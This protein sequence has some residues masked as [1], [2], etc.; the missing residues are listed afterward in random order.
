MK[1]FTIF[2]ITLLCT[3]SLVTAA[4]IDIIPVYNPPVE[5]KIAPLDLPPTYHTTLANG[6]R[7]TTIPQHEVP[8]VSFT[9]AIGNGALLDPIGKEGTASMTASLLDRGTDKH[10]GDEIA[11]ELDFMATAISG[12]SDWYNSYVRFGCLTRYLEPTLALFSEVL[13][14]PVFPQREFDSAIT[15]GVSSMQQALDSPG[16]LVRKHFRSAVYKGSRY[17]IGAEGDLET[18]PAITREDVVAFHHEYYSPAVTELIIVGDVE[19]QE[20]V[21][22]VEAYLGDWRG[23]ATES[24]VATAL[25][26]SGEPGVIIINKPEATNANLRFGHLGVQRNHPDYY[27]LQVMNS[28]LGG[29]GFS[30]R[31][32]QRIRTELGYTYGIYSGFRYQLDTGSFSV[33]AA[34]SA[35]SLQ[36][37]ISEALIIINTIREEPVGEKE[38]RDARTFLAASYPLAFENPEYLARKILGA[39][40]YG[41]PESD[42]LNYSESILAVTKEDVLRVARR[43]ITPGSFQFIICG[44]AAEL[45]EQVEQ[46]GTVTIVE[47][48]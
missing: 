33:G 23:S 10:S 43:Y 32:M 40:V 8:T 4:S 47:I 12:Y 27:A 16:R 6:L 29:G 14:H 30:S 2:T 1:C 19:H 38:L 25:P 24:T 22:L 46:F 37:A 42:I 26:R 13:L 45:Q 44:N 36:D 28:I 9:L 17:A 3:V 21:R 20:I 15:R 18:L 35:S 11:A 39:H 7:I 31:L 5:Q 41:L 48:N 34:V